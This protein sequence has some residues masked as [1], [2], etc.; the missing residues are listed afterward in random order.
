M[1][2]EAASWKPTG[3]STLR[4]W[5]SAILCSLLAVALAGCAGAYRK[6]Q[7]PSL[8]LSSLEM[9]D[10]TL[11]EQRF[12]LGLRVTNPNDK[13]L[14]IRGASANLEVNGIE[15]ASGVSGDRAEVPAYG[16]TVVNFTAT[17]SLARI[18]LQLGAMADKG[19]VD[20]RLRGRISIANL[21]VSI[22][23]DEKGELD[24][25]QFANWN[26]RLNVQ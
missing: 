24:F 15:F 11:F 10:S 14:T 7:P 4:I 16:D 26:R 25:Q 23:F 3:V 9:L 20:Y 8:T 18:L 22:P 19:K 12:L 21:P 5:L 2:R 1:Y 13:P 6:M 17:T